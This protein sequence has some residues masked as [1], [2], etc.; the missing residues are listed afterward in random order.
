GFD[1]LLF[2]VAIELIHRVQ[3]LLAILDD[4]LDDLVRRKKAVGR[5]EGLPGELA[6]DVIHRLRPGA[7]KVRTMLG[8]SMEEV[9]GP[10]GDRK[11]V[12]WLSEPSRPTPLP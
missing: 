7:V 9:R 11:N 12:G 1:V 5:G 8:Y 4:E 3:S 2:L 10:G 6:V